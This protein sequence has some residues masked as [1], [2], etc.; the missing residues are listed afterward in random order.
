MHGELVSSNTKKDDEFVNDGT[1]DWVHGE[2]KQNA[3]EPFFPAMQGAFIC[4]RS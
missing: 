3:A 2:V 1:S 4:L